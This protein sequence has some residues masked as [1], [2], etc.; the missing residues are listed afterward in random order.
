M[1]LG[2]WIIIMFGSG[3][4][5]MGTATSRLRQ[6]SD[7]TA[8]HALSHHECITPSVSSTCATA[9]SCMTS[10]LA[11]ADGAFHL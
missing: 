9:L 8:H 4:L 11:D 5:P 3:A 6:Q 10:F 7:V 1:M 2:L